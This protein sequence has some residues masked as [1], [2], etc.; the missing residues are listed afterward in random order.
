[1]RKNIR[2]CVRACQCVSQYSV[3]VCVWG[4]MCTGTGS[5]MSSMR[6]VNLPISG[7]KLQLQL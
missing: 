3:S 1:M 5:C 7:M 4:C 2:M 6:Y